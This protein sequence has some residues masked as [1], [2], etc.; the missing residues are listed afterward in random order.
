MEIS[1]VAK[2][3]LKGAFGNQGDLLVSLTQ[4]LH[5]KPAQSSY[6]DIQS[7]MDSIC[8]SQYKINFGYPDKLDGY[9]SS[10]GVTSEYVGCN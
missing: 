6:A 8:A 4:A 9:S 3:D 2:V 10:R 1:R 5:T 7:S